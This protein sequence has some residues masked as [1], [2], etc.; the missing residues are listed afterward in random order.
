MVLRKTYEKA[1]TSKGYNHLTYYKQISDGYLEDKRD[2]PNKVSKALKV[3]L[4]TILQTDR[5]RFYQ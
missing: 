4:T 1:C 2:S 5:T 3:Q